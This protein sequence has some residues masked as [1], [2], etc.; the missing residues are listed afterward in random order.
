MFF[1]LPL[2]RWRGTA[3]FV[4]TLLAIEFLDEFVYGARETAW[5]AIRADLGLSYDQIGLLL[6]IPTLVSNLI[7]PALGI[8]ADVWKRRWIILGGGVVFFLG[9]ILVA[10]SNSF[11]AL[12]LSFIFVGPASGAFVSLSQ[13]TL[14]DIE[15]D[16]HEN[17]MA[18]WEFAGSLGVV[19][20]S[21]VLSGFAVV[22]LNW[23]DF[24][25][26]AAVLAFILWFISLHTYPTTTAFEATA[27]PDSADDE[28][29]S[30]VDG[31]RAALQA[32]RRREVLRWLVLLQFSD[33]MGDVLYAYLALY[34]VDVAGVSVEQ[35]GIAVATWT[36]IGLLGDFLLIPL[37]E[38]VRGLAYL[39]ISAALEF[40]LF[41]AF[42]LVPG[43]LP[44]LVILGLLGIFNAGWYSILQGQLYSAMPGQSGT[45]LALGNI[46][47]LVGGLIPLVIGLAAERFGLGAAAWL[48]LLGPIALLI[49]LPRA[50]GVLK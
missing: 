29:L 3:V 18:R 30:F 1:S 34:M 27:E 33:L 48:F 23:R 47:G 11:L 8:L 12:M 4:L 13:S 25:L 15:P 22:G 36:G 2:R 14:M 10:T 46:S 26:A 32:L 39:R 37:L 5:P 31:A 41:A 44:K 9:L 38:R 7:E 28:Q 42:L 40:I 20:G 45:V 21:L 16:R 19:A 17:N 6:T 50:T 35:A 24:F 43:F 49:G